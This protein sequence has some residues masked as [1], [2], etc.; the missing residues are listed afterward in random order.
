MAALGKKIQS[1]WYLVEWQEQKGAYSVFELDYVL[2]KSV[3]IG[4]C[5]V[6]D[7]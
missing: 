3:V 6:A 5:L 2:V 7:H 1:I 4:G